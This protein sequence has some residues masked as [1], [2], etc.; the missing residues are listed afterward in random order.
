MWPGERWEQAREP[1]VKTAAKEGDET[2]DVTEKT[3]LYGFISALSV[4][5]VTS[6][7]RSFSW[8]EQYVDES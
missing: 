3:D 6:V 7:V 1:C 8:I 4:F 2:T 5:S